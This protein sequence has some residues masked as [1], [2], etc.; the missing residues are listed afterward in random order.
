MT[1]VSSNIM[2]GQEGYYGTG[3]FQ[4]MLNINQVNKMASA[5]LEEKI[6][7]DEF[8]QVDKDDVCSKNNIV[9]NTSTE[10]I[11]GKYSGDISTEY[12]PGF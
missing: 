6:N 3:S 11:S 5:Q 12:D 1:G 4:I 2:C 8:L 7:I 10:Y 9:M